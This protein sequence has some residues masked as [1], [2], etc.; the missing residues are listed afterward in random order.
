MA[1]LRLETVW[2]AD[3]VGLTGAAS[4]AASAEFEF[5]Y[6]VRACESRVAS[7]LTICCRGADWSVPSTCPAV[8]V[9]PS[10]T[11]TEPMVPETAKDTD[12]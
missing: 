5:A 10:P 3:V 7:L 8:T 12:S 9:C 1:L 6:C 11:F 4:V 2:A